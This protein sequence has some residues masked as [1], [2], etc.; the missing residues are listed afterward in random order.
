[1]ANFDQQTMK[2]APDSN[3]AYTVK[4]RIH[5]EMI[6]PM[7]RQ[8]EPTAELTN[9]PQRANIDA[10]RDGENTKPREEAEPPG[11]LTRERERERGRR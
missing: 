8:H 6:A 11:G 4:R 10:R 9:L 7:G 3:A 1:M 2:Q 5:P